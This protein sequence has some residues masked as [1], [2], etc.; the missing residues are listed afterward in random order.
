MTHL[1]LGDRVRGHYFSFGIV[2]DRAGRPLTG[3]F[4][5]AIEQMN[6][7]R[8]DFEM[9]VGDFMESVSVENQSTAFLANM[10]NLVI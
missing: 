5:K 8:P 4:E 9:S 2:S 1:N 3:V 7:L 10:R 6:R